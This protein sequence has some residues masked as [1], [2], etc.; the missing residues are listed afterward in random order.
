[1]TQKTDTIR[2][3][4]LAALM[5]V[6]VFG[7]TIAFTAPAKADSRTV[8]DSSELTDAIG[9]VDEVIIDSNIELQSAVELTDETI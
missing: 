6:S 5:V 4:F 8:S 7:A 3:L 2:A 9:S 1:M